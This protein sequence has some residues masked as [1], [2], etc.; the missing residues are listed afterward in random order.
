MARPA[1][2]RPCRRLARGGP[3][4]GVAGLY[5]GPAAP[6]VR[7]EPPAPRQRHVAARLRHADG[8]ERRRRGADADGAERRSMSAATSALTGG[9]PSGSGKSTLGNQAAVPAQEGAGGDQSVRPQPSR[10]PI[11]WHITYSSCQL[12]DMS[13]MLAGR[14]GDRPA[15]AGTRA[16]N[17]AN[18]RDPVMTSHINERKPGSATID[19][20]EPGHDE[21][22][23]RSGEAGTGAITAGSGQAGGPA[24]RRSA[25]SST[26]PK[27]PAAR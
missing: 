4:A 26:T 10:S 11:T 6:G 21:A 2:H 13:R 22:R 17:E 1:R 25:G 27:V 18:H 7:D 16:V 20:G 24:D 19:I 5:P 9:R 23:P 12:R 14:A 3:A 8:A 15:G